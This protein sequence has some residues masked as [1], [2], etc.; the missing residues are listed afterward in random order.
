MAARVYDVSLLLADGSTKTVQ[1]HGNTRKTAGRQALASYRR[2]HGPES[3]Q[4]VMRT[5]FRPTHAPGYRG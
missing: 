3:A 5:R 4:C 2:E 1:G